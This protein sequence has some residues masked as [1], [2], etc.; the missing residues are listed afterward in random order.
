MYDTIVIGLGPAG[1]TAAIYLKRFNNDVL[2]I[3]K[4]LGALKES[5]MIENYYGFAEPISGNI[6]VANG[7]KQAERHGVPIIRDSVINIDEHDNYFIVTTEHAVFEAKTILLA[8]GKNRKRLP[9]EGFNAYRG[10]GISLCVTCDGFFFRKKKIGIIGD[11]PYMLHELSLLTNLTDDITIFSNGINIK[12]DSY[13]VVTEP[14]TGFYGDSKLT[15]LKT[16]NATYQLDGV[17]VAIGSPSALEFA[18]SLGI[19]LDKETIIVDDNFQTNNPGVFAAG[20]V[21]GGFLQI[22]K[23]VCDGTNAAR[24]IHEYLRKK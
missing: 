9:V 4:D 7:I 21:I 1:A 19:I 12:N 14:I 10:K 17:F 11:G 23:A 24:K 22:S 13:K 18:Q 6:I 20:D 8:T 15:S 2:L 16:S 5:D 3:G